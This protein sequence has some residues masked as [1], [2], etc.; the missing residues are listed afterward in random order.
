MSSALSIAALFTYSDIVFYLWG[1]AA[2][3]AAAAVV[4]QFSNC[5]GSEWSSRERAQMLALAALT[6]FM[7]VGGAGPIVGLAV[8]PFWFLHRWRT[9]RAP[10]MI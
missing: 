4:L 5:A 2:V 8:I 3:S 7:A 9:S 10:R 6:A 1:V